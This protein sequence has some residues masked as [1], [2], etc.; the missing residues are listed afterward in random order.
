MER[1]QSLAECAALE[2]QYALTC[3]G[4]SNPSLSALGNDRQSPVKPGLFFFI[5][6]PPNYRNE[7][8]YSVS[9]AK[10]GYNLGYRLSFGVFCLWENV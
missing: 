5:I 10:T 7:S 6:F 8:K 1:W 3:I 9:F 2:M 4:G